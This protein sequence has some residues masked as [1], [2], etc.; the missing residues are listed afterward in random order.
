[1]KRLSIIL[2]ILLLAMGCARTFAPRITDTFVHRK[3]MSREDC[4]TCHVQ[5]DKVTPKAPKR[6]LKVDRENCRKCHW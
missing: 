3:S 2:G 6:M 4:L 1:M 5:G